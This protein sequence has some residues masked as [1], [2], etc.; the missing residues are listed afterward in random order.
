MKNNYKK[1]LSI[2]TLLVVIFFSVFLLYSNNKKADATVTNSAGVGYGAI[3]TDASNDIAIGTSTTLANT[4]LFILAST[5]DSSA[6]GITIYNSN[7]SSIF[8]VRNDGTVTAPV[9]SGGLVGNINAA[10]IY[11]GQ[12]GSNTG[13]LLAPYSFAGSVGIGITNPGA[14]LDLYSVVSD[15]N[16][17]TYGIRSYLS[18]VEPD[19]LNKYY[20]YGG[21]FSA[22]DGGFS[23]DAG[24]YGIYGSASDGNGNSVGVYG[25]SADGN[26]TGVQGY[27]SSGV[28][29]NFSSWGETGAIISS[30]IGTG[31]I[32]Y[33][34]GYAALTVYNS[35]SSQL[36]INSTQGKNYF[37]G[38]VGIGTTN[39]GAKLEVNG[40]VKLSGSTPTYTITNVNTPNNSSDVATKGYVDTSVASA[41]PNGWNCTSTQSAWSGQD[42]NAYA[43]CP[44]T[45]HIVSGGCYWQAGTS[46]IVETQTIPDLKDNAWQC[47]YYT[48]YSLAYA[49][50]CK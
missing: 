12:F 36:A 40:N 29:G 35:S 22:D 49:L 20:G 47:Y 18:F 32:T 8:S 50:C 37:G 1:I 7:N 14:K 9:F 17:N 5:S 31:L 46:S 19:S 27:S 10:N 33:S 25:V 41:K 2:F 48:G 21:Y 3:A 38:N 23:S 24:I 44:A 42:N 4:K 30:N 13:A 6:Y 15:T 34:G 28:G 45:F 16:A 43:Y 11:S 39:P 26:G